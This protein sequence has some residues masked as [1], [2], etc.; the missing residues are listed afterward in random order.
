MEEGVW[1]VRGVVQNTQCC[2][3]DDTDTVMLLSSHDL[4]MPQNSNDNLAKFFRPF[5]LI[6]PDTE[7]KIPSQIPDTA[8]G[9]LG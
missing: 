9:I 4:P 6:D 3:C 5:V 1:Q 8:K 2:Y 7:C